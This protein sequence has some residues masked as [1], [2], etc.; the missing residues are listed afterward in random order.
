MQVCLFWSSAANPPPPGRPWVRS[1]SRQ[2]TGEAEGAAALRKASWVQDCC[3]CSP[4]T[5]RPA[6]SVSQASFLL[7]TITSHGIIESSRHWKAGVRSPEAFSSPSQTSPVPL[8]HR[9]TGNSSSFT[10]LGFTG[11]AHLYL[12]V[13]CT[14]D[15]MPDAAGKGAVFIN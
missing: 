3:T 14:G 12:H 10:I 5:P 2:G 9:L 1:D 7:N 13:P 6:G 4:V 11:L 15:P 8:Q